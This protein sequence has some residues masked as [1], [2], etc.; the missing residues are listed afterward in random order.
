MK[1]FWPLL[2]LVIPYQSIHAQEVQHAPTVAQCR[3]DQSLWLSKL[4]TQGLTDINLV[5]YNGLHGWVGEMLDCVQVDPQFQ[6]RYGSTIGETHAAM[7]L[8][9]EKF[10][11]RHNLYN[12]FL[13]EDA[14]GKR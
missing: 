7:N 14:A 13:A 11:T 6:T 9:L 3:A 8:R 5:S 4:E 12:Q 2:L 1:R 10:L